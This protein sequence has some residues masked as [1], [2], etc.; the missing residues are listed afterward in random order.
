DEYSEVADPLVS[1]EVTTGAL[2]NDLADVPQALLVGL[3]HHRAGHAS[4][5]LWWRQAS[6]LSAWGERA[7]SATRALLSLIPHPRPGLDD[8]PLADG[9]FD[10]LHRESEQGWSGRP[11]GRDA[12]AVRPPGCPA[13][14]SCTGP[15]ACGSP[16]TAPHRRGRGSR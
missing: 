9:E 8:A 11:T 10:A 4:E 16:A 15:A 1:A 5:A 12:A 3:Q 14:A 7:A 13:P 6:Y 2:S